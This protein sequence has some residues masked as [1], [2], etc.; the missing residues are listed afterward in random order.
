M[1]SSHIDQTMSQPPRPLSNKH[2]LEAVEG[3]KFKKTMTIL[4]LQCDTSR[5]NV[6]VA[7]S[8]I[9]ESVAAAYL[10]HCIPEAAEV[11][12]PLSVEVSSTEN[13]EHSDVTCSIVYRRFEKTAFIIDHVDNLLIS[14]DHVL[15]SMLRLHSLGIVH[16]DISPQNIGILPS[17]DAMLFD[18]DGVFFDFFPCSAA[19]NAALFNEMDSGGYFTSVGITSPT[20]M[21][22]SVAMDYCLFHY[23][24]T[25]RLNN[26]IDW[27]LEM[28]LRGCEDDL[29]EDDLPEDEDEGCLMK[30]VSK[31]NM[32]EILDKENYVWSISSQTKE[33][34]EGEI[35]MQEERGDAFI[36][37]GCVRIGT[38]TQ[39][40]T[41]RADVVHDKESVYMNYC[42]KNINALV[43]NV[44]KWTKCDNRRVV[45][46]IAACI[47]NRMLGKQLLTELIGCG[48]LR[49]VFAFAMENMLTVKENAEAPHHITA[50]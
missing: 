24:M 3:E 39:H 33:K 34:E 16:G 23:T 18:Y 26:R 11:N 25:K 14:E 6:A 47:C 45:M 9:I 38:T 13:A 30:K 49:T 32:L 27:N 12:I 44:V 40:M 19:P 43:M 8:G 5:D 36:F 2:R 28:Y 21:V 4:P 29:P 42:N 22:S 31:N 37:E 20:K 10:H 46:A 48:P 17:G 1:S 15:P 35:D 41:G 50:F 7:V